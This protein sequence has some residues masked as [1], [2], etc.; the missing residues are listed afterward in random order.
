MIGSV[1]AGV[2]STG[3]SVAGG[4]VSVGVSVCVGAVCAE[5]DVVALVELRTNGVA[6]TGTAGDS[7]CVVV[8]S[9]VFGVSWPDVSFS[10][11]SAT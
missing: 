4:V 2:S 10:F 5:S 7:V 3:V 6:S 9:V 8:G 11:S 1:S